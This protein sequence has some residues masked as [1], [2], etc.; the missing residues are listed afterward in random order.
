MGNINRYIMD[1][2]KPIVGKNVWPLICPLENKP[3]K[4]A[5]FVVEYDR[6]G[7]YG[8]NSEMGWMHFVSIMFFKKSTS[9]KKPVNILDERKEI[10]KA[11]IDAGFAVTQITYF[12]DTEGGYS[13]MTF[14][15]NIEEDVVDPPAEDE[16]DPDP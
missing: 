4:F 3:S 15:A 1:T 12:H 16:E 10:R 6:P 13:Y 14:S 9:N 8:D 5:T 2:L 11:L 7:D